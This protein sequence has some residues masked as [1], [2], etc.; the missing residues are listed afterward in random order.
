MALARIFMN[1]SLRPW[2]SGGLLHLLGPDDARRVEQESPT[3][4]QD[5]VEAT[6][7]STDVGSNDATL[8]N[9]SESVHS[10]IPSGNETDAVWR[11]LEDIAPRRCQVI[12]T[13]WELGND[14]AASPNVQ[15]RMFLQNLIQLMRLPKGSIGFWPMA[16][17]ASGELTPSVER[18]WS[19]VKRHGALKVCCFG[20]TA[21][22]CLKGSSPDSG[23]PPGASLHHFPDIDE[24]AGLPGYQFMPHLLHL[25]RVHDIRLT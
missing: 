16:V 22:E 1:E 25:F 11:R 13:Y 4:E 24:L 7:P 9:N 23:Q 14:M 10:T 19:G 17:P 6:V 3:R 2:H 8:Q 5:A 18:F 21:S 15:R 12:W 20:E